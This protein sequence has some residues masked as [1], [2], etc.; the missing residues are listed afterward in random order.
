MFRIIFIKNSTY[1]HAVTQK[2]KKRIMS[3]KK[4]ACLNDTCQYIV[5]ISEID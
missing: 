2:K 4:M 5:I 3:Y 1:A